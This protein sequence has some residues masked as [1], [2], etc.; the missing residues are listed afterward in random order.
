[1]ATDHSATRSRLLLATLL[2]MTGVSHVAWPQP[3][4][5]LVPRWLPGSPAAWNR[6]A[7][8]A[9]LGS[10]ALLAYRRTARLG[11][12]GAFATVAGVWVAN[13][14]AALDGGYRALPGHLGG[15]TVAWVRVPLQVP[16]LW[17]AATIARRLD[18][19]EA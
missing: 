9:E 14:Q 8:A 5:R 18:E 6:L 10:A 1:M 16:L 19:P 13:I 2:A 7:T 11:G 4:E 17:W 12:V 3:F 15:R